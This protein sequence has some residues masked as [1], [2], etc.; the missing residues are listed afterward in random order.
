MAWE[1]PN[2]C[3]GNLTAAADLSA[4]QYRCVK[5]TAD[6]QINLADTQGEVI[7]G[8]LQDKPAQGEAAEVTVVGVTKVVAG[9]A[10][11]AGQAWGV[12]AQGR[13]VPV[14]PGTGGTVGDFI[15]G[16]VVEGA[17]NAGE[18]ATVTVGVPTLVG[19]V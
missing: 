14:T 4:S 5:V 19:V 7:L 17:A 6:N 2:F 8:V 9:A 11:T 3:I 12:D 18:L 1:L 16:I 10:L 15:A 13:A